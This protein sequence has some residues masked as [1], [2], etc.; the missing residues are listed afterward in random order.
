MECPNCDG[1]GREMLPC[2]ECFGEDGTGFCI[3]CKNTLHILEKCE[4]CNGSGKI[5]MDE[6]DER[7]I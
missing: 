1:M 3:T 4:D 5:D 2:A 6:D 7:L